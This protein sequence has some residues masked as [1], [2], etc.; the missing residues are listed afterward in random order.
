MPCCQ[1]K[2]DFGFLVVSRST[3]A[4]FQYEKANEEKI[5]PRRQQAS[6][7][8]SNEDKLQSKQKDWSCER[9]RLTGEKSRVEGVAGAI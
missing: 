8:A 3:V 4:G 1:R 6:Q 2:L 7:Q 9:R 5:P